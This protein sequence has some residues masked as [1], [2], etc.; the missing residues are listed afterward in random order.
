MTGFE[1]RV[2]SICQKTCADEELRLKLP[3]C[4]IARKE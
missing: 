1:I 2:F 4:D 3:L